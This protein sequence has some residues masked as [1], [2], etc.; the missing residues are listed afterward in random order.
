M[1]WVRHRRETSSPRPEGAF[2]YA[3]KDLLRFG[4][5]YL[6]RG[7]QSLPLQGKVAER[8]EVGRGRSPCGIA[9]LRASS[10]ENDLFRLSAKMQAF[11]PKSTFP[12]GGRLSTARFPKAFPPLG[13]AMLPR[14][15][16]KPSPMP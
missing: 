5:G 9:R 11:F 1:T 7:L 13:K 8:S 16:Q 10:N 4:K 3:L 14:G 6:P 2:P 15:L 12:Q